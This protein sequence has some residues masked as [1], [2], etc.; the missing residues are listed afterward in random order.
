MLGGPCPWEWVCELQKEVLMLLARL[1]VQSAFF[2]WAPCFSPSPLWSALAETA[3]DTHDIPLSSDKNLQP[4]KNT[5]KALRL[6]HILVS[7]TQVECHAFQFPG[8]IPSWSLYTT[9]GRKVGST[10]AQSFYLP[11]Y[12]FSWKSVHKECWK[13][14]RT[15]F[16]SVLLLTSHEPMGSVD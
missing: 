14:N 13:R 6:R 2:L 3:W 7:L 9:S 15:L 16:P 11:Y 5:R 8:Q 1:S 12:R 10:C 4:L